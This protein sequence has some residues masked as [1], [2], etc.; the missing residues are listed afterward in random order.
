MSIRKWPDASAGED[1]NIL[2]YNDTFSIFEYA[3]LALQWFCGSGLIE[4]SDGNLSPQQEATRAQVAVVLMR[5]F[6]IYAF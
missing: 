2:S 5:F 1:T 3:I 4:G 6:D